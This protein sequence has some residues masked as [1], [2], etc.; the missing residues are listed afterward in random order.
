M[1]L[2]HVPLHARQFSPIHITVTAP[3]AGVQAEEAE[4]QLPVAVH[5]R[6]AAEQ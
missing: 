5:M 2:P 3:E 4:F 1:L 6:A